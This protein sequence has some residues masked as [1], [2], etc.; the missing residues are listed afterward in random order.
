[1]QNG[2]FFVG[3]VA[4]LV[5][6]QLNKSIGFPLAGWGMFLCAAALYCIMF[7][8]I[9]LLNT[10]S[11]LNALLWSLKQYVHW[12]LLT[13]LLFMVLPLVFQARLVR[14]AILL[15]ALAVALLSRVIPV[16]H[17]SSLSSWPA[18]LIDALPEQAVVLTVV[19]LCW[20]LQQRF[21]SNERQADRPVT[22]P[23]TPCQPKPEQ[24]VLVTKG[25]GE[26]LIRWSS[27]DFISA[28]GN[29]VE[30]S[31]NQETYLL[32]ATMKQL[33]QRLPAGDF[34]RIHRC[35]IVNLAAID[36]IATQPA[37]NGSVSL[38]GGTV[39]PLSKSYKPLLRTCKFTTAQS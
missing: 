7:N 26:C 29:Y 39:L 15:I 6:Y 12:L 30:L 37:G 10:E 3:A 20:Q 35:H 9:V 24:T 5:P 33:E 4:K 19:V 17:T 14:C 36:R 22:S 8:Q 27:V 18:A 2:V 13:P 38:R 1:M 34:I 21:S 11:F 16:L 28:A 23:G 32:R 31:S 25:Q